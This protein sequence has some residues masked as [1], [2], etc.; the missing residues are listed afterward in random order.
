ML[1]NRKFHFYFDFPIIIFFE[2]KIYF[3]CSPCHIAI[4]LADILSSEG[5]IIN[6]NERFA[7]AIEFKRNMSLILCSG[8][9]LPFDYTTKYST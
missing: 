3:T 1:N 7:V 9:C 2:Q 4:Y 8:Y 5:V 6:Y